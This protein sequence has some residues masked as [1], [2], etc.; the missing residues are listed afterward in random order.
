MA[1]QR[2]GYIHTHEPVDLLADRTTC[3]PALTHLTLRSPSAEPFCRRAVKT[4]DV[5]GVVISTIPDDQEMNT[6]P[7][8]TA[9]GMDQHRD[10]KTGNRLT[11][12]TAANDTVI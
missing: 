4:I 8:N 6:S 3:M 5:L 12:H 7:C 9:E 2:T 10:P 1:T 11:G